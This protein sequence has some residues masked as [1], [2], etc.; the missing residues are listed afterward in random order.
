MLNVSLCYF[1]LT[2]FIKLGKLP[3]VNY[4]RGNRPSS[5]FPEGQSSREQLYGWGDFFRGQLSGH[6]QRN[7]LNEKAQEQL[8][9]L[10][11]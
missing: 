3:W 5:N 2:V 7:I 1:S 8:N 4:L 9:Y 11:Y 10:N 6:H